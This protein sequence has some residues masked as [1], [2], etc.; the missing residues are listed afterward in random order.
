MNEIDGCFVCF[1][2]NI[3]IVGKVRGSYFLFDLYFRFVIGKL[4]F[5]GKSICIFVNNL[6]GVYKYII[7][8]VYFMEIISVI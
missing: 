2:E 6:F 5:E 4:M 3:M 1:S 7:D 8:L